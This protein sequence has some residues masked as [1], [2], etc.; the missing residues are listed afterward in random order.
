MNLNPGGKQAIMRNT[1]FGP[2][3]LL[4][5]MVFP[6]TY[7]DEKLRGRPK[8][9]KQVLIEREK[10]PLGGLVLECNKCTKTFKNFLLCMSS[11]ILRARFSCSKRCY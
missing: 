3:N 7:H 6:V 11:N 10:W 2:N 8:G 1:Y 9:I 5:S 4:Q